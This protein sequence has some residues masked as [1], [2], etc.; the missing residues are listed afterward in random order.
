M[1]SVVSLECQDSGLIP[2]PVWWVKDL[3]LL[4][5]L[6][7]GFQLWIGSDLWPRNSI[8]CWV[9]KKEE[10]KRISLEE[11]ALELC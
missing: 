7:R 1:E 8:C 11:T 9:A 5:Q 6:W 4:Q 2:G 3:A 10:K